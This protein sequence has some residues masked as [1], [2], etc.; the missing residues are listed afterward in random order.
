MKMI[1]Y[2]MFHVSER[3]EATTARPSGFVTW[4]AWRIDGKKQI[5]KKWEVLCF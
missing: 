3:N 5:K 4:V 2:N 1:I